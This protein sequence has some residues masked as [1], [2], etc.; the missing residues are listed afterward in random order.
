MTFAAEQGNGDPGYRQGAR[1][2]VRAPLGGE[3]AAVVASLVAN[4]PGRPRRT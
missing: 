1:A 4:R 2:T 3:P